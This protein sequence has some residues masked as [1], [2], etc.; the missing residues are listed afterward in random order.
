MPPSAV[1]VDCDWKCESPEKIT[2]INNWDSKE[3]NILDELK[4]ALIEYGPIT[5]NIEEWWHYVVLVEY[6]RILLNDTIYT[7]IGGSDD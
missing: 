3:T 4:K 2:K 5:I 1:N 7:D 6:G